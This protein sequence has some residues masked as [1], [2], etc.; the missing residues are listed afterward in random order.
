MITIDIQRNE[1]NE[2][3]SFTTSG[4]AY[5]DEPGRDIVCAAVS[6]LT[7]TMLLGVYEVLKVKLPYKMKHGYLTCN[8]PEDISVEKRQQINILFET[9]VVGLKNIQENYCQYIDLHDKE[10]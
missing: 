10:V 5:A 3:I 7:Q 2:I 9:M 4:H 6:T 1:N 8:I